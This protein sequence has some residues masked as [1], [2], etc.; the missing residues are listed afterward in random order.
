M[1]DARDQ[2]ELSLEEPQVAAVLVST[3]PNRWAT[4]SFI[5]SAGSLLVWL[6]TGIPLPAIAGLGGLFGMF[7]LRAVRQGQRKGRWMAW[8]SVVLSWAHLLGT[9]FM[10]SYASVAWFTLGA[11]LFCW[12]LCGRRAFA[13][14]AVGANFL[15]L[16]TVLG[17]T[18]T[19]V[20]EPRPSKF[21]FV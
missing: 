14:H 5:L 3:A 13:A 8:I 16:L 7:G 15:L 2:V 11:A 19:G 12:G 10:F 20:A 17:L 21:A 18:I 9:I 4:A 1:S 6:L